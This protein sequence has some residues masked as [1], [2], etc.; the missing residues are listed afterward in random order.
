MNMLAEI[1]RKGRERR[2]DGERGATPIEILAGLVLLGIIFSFI[3]V[4]FFS[5]RETTQDKGAQ[6][7]LRNAALA[8]ESIYTT[9]GNYGTAATLTAAPTN[10]NDVGGAKNLNC[11]EPSLEFIAATINATNLSGGDTIHVQVSN[12][13]STPSG[14]NQVLTLT[15]V[16]DSGRIWCQQIVADDGF[17]TGPNAREVGTYF[18][19]GNRPSTW[20]NNAC[21]GGPTGTSSATGWRSKF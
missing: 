7:N 1:L 2:A 10:C 14:V 5:W 15:T 9:E 20:N 12:A 19:G 6:G 11:I 16:S 17:G 13:N 21:A 3:I 8:A 4:K 18:G